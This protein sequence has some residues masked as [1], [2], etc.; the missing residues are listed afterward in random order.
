[1]KRI[2]RLIIITLALFLVGAPVLAGV[3]GPDQ[4]QTEPKPLPQVPTT[5]TSSATTTDQREINLASNVEQASYPLNKDIVL[6]ITLSW[7][8]QE[9]RYRL[10]RIE[11]PEMENLLILGSETGAVKEIFEQEISYRRTTTYRLRAEKTGRASAGPATAYYKEGDQEQ[12][13]L[14]ASGR[15]EME[16]TDAKYS[17][18]EQEKNIRIVIFIAALLVLGL[19]LLAIR[20]LLV[21]REAK[22]P[23]IVVTVEE[24]PTGLF[25]ADLA[26]AEKLLKAGDY[27]KL[28]AAVAEAVS[29]LAT[30][31]YKLAQRTETT[32]DLLIRLASADAPDDLVRQLGQLLESCDYTRFSGKVLTHTE[33]SEL[34][35]E[36][37]RIGE[38]IK[39]SKD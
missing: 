34:F 28:N 24:S 11:P 39:K 15:I 37:R 20:H 23:E 35:A 26:G 17:F 2:F 16:I 1:M 18:F 10:D 38:L 33:A 22:K 36:L 31:T 30:R 25:E 4:N 12:L 7:T 27:G 19:I 21:K 13:Q 3:I 6:T 32:T 29:H 8:G 5:T 9:D 14:I